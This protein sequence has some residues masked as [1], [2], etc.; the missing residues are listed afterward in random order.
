MDAA[1][2]FV[3]TCLV[4]GSEKLSLDIEGF[5]GPLGE[6]GDWQIICKKKRR[7]FSFR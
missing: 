2:L 5:H 3:V 7:W 1:K 4:H 6:S